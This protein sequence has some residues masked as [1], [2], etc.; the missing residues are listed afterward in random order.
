[1][2]KSL[3][4]CLFLAIAIILLAL[5]AVVFMIKNVNNNFLEDKSKLDTSW[6]N[7]TTLLHQRNE[8][9]YKDESLKNIISLVNNSEALIK[10]K[11]NKKELLSNEYAL[12]DSLLKNK[13]LEV[14]NQKLN[15]YLSLYNDNVREFNVKYSAFPYSAI[16][17]KHKVELYD[18]FKIE[19]G[20]DNHNL[21]KE[22]KK[23]DEWI[24]NG[25]ELK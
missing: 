21:I 18:Y 3:K 6:N 23:V 9:L 14:V 16:R 2:N 4:G 24:E 13:N 7:Y 8:N 22:Q 11:N 1:M 17:K 25:G 15:D 12:S 20:K 10:V 5:G 19:Y